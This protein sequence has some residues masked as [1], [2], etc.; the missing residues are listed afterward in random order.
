MFFSRRSSSKEDALVRAQQES[1]L[2][3]DHRGQVFG[4]SVRGSWATSAILEMLLSPNVK[5][6]QKQAVDG[7]TDEIFRTNHPVLLHKSSPSTIFFGRE[8]HFGRLFLSMH[9]A[10][11]S[12]SWLS[13]PA[14]GPGTG[15]FVVLAR[16]SIEC[17][18]RTGPNPKPLTGFDGEKGWERSICGSNARCGL[19]S[20][21]PHK[22]IA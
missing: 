18:V 20:Q 3:T 22:C 19:R 2:P 11:L 1:S 16:A 15:R 14:N 13:N 10:M 7:R 21:P 6:T 4:S 17:L 9:M 8:A 5:V 12:A